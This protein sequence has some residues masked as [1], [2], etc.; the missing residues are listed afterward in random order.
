M[1]KPVTGSI[2]CS[3]TEKAEI[4]LPYLNREGFVVLSAQTRSHLSS[5]EESLVMPMVALKIDPVK[6]REDKQSHYHSN[7]TY[8]RA[9]NS[10]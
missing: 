10:S 3:R 4:P 5:A 8:S 6:L 1:S 2:A 9:M 7:M